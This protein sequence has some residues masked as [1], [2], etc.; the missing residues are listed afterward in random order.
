M[1]AGLVLQYMSLCFKDF[2]LNLEDP[3][4]F[5]RMYSARR[6]KQCSCWAKV[7]RKLHDYSFHKFSVEEFSPHL[8]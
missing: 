3:L 8:K 4:G 7:T 5:V 2:F 1:T 6:V